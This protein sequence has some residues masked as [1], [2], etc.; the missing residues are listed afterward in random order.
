VTV[1]RSARGLVGAAAVLLACAAP[2]AA[3]ER[4]APTAARPVAVATFAAG[5]FWCSEADF[6]KV[7]GV[8]GV[9]SGYTG[10]RVPDPTYEQV[11]AGGTGHL[12][13]VRVEYDPTRVTYAQL[14][15]TF[16]R[17]VDPVDARG[18]FCDKGEQYTGAILV[19]TPEERALAE[20]S[21]QRIAARFAARG[22]AVA[23]RILP[24]AP[25]YVAEAYHQDYAKKNPLRYRFYRGSCGRDA[26]LRELRDEVG[27]GG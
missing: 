21:K 1:R 25:F 6:E 10:G 14:L 16:W 9:V 27:R 3:Q 24:A 26:R 23:T 12:E 8:T 18:Q 20:A 5:C 13:A 7:P 19:A 2:A 15:D 17:N 22:Q 11:S 4:P